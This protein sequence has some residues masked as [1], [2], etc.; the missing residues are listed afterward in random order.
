[1]QYSHDIIV[2]GGGAAGLVC[3]SGC[4]QLGMKVALVERAS[5]GGDC[6]HFGCVPSKTLLSQSAAYQRSGASDLSARDIFSTI[7]DTINTIAVHDS[8]ERFESLGAEVY[9]GE[10][11]FLNKHT[12]VIQEH[13]TP[14]YL[15][16]KKIVIATGS[17]PKIPPIKGLK[18]A[19][20]VTNKSIFSLN[21]IPKR[22]VIL[23]GGPIG[24]E[25]AQA[26][27]QLGSSVI[28][29]EAADDILM[30]EDQ[31][32]I[33]LITEQLI[34]QGV[35]VLTNTQVQEVS[36]ERTKKI[37]HISD[38]SPIS[39]DTLLVAA[40]RKGNT[41]R[42]GLSEINV[43]TDR[44]FIQVDKKLR[45]SQKHITAIGDVNGQCLFTHVAEAEGSLAIRRLALRLGGT[46]DYTNVPSVVYTNPEIAKVG[47]TEK[48][49]NQE[50]LA[51]DVYRQPFSS[52]DRAHAEQNIQGFLKILC[53][54]RSKKII[55]G[56]IVGPQAGELLTPLLFAVYRRWRVSDFRM[57][58]PYPI[59]SE[60]YKKL[61]SKYLHPYLFNNRVRGILRFFFRYRGTR[62][63][64]N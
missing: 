13:T 58:F 42:L 26:F 23:G 43:A 28:L 55:G 60:I 10:A 52:V 15:S 21:Y 24:V 17:S 25:M 3:V 44:G 41:D 64:K 6:L 32:A 39:C 11:K 8:K 56:Q 57:M 49:A 46:M 50:G 33:E 62:F 16:A 36:Q 48:R 19:S 63:E 45:T 30:N 1:M 37:I 18:Y 22:L 61:S 2:I 20:Y 29:I 38:G 31:E 53:H 59:R 34:H 51:Y 27:I 12:V 7:D 5:L 40:G 35:R 4:A 9:M 47:Y 14:A 54:R